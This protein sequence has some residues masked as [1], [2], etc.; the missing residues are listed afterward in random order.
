[1]KKLIFLGLAAIPALFS[2]QQKFTLIPGAGFGW[3][4]GKIPDAYGS[5]MK[6][7]LKEL[8]SGFNFDIGGYYR[9]N[10]MIGLGLK[11]NL[12][13]ASASGT[14]T[15]PGPNDQML[16]GTVQTDDK[17]NFVGPA[18]MYSNFD[19]NTKHKLYYDMALGVISYTSKTGTVT[20][21]G[22]NLG[23][24]ATIG[25]MYALSPNIYLGPQ[26]GY[27][28]GTLKKIKVNGVEKELDKDSYESLHRVSAGLGATFRF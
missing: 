6:D 15:V 2:A 5:Q 24:A 10:D 28:G 8:K 25:Y 12:Y 20:I 18:F 4:I 22:S 27:T 17:I 16:T 3:R 9:V 23:L 11:Y 13:T 21:K 7:Y 14:L 1:M 19:E 26:V